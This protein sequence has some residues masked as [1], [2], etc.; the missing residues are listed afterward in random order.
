V[1]LA[2][3]PPLR[4]RSFDDDRIAEPENQSTND[5]DAI[6]E[7]RCLIQWRVGYGS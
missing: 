1:G 5:K 7:R 6:K 2:S 3:F 4:E